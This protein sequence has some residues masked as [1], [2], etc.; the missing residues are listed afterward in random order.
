MRVYMVRASKMP[1]VSLVL[2]KQR[3]GPSRSESE[4]WCWAG[5]GR[6]ILSGR[7]YYGKNMLFLSTLVLLS[8]FSGVEAR[9]ASFRH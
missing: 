2:Y 7:E 1:L 6:G 3:C 9:L 4:G 5:R 8:E